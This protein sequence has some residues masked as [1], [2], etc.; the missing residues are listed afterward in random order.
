MAALW[1]SATSLDFAPHSILCRDRT[2]LTRSSEP[3][4]HGFAIGR[5]GEKL[6]SYPLDDPNAGKNPAGVGLGKLGGAKG[7]AARPAAI[8]TRRHQAI[9][10]KVARGHGGEATGL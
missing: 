9:A 1:C 5:F 8:S 6:A 3:E 4:D 2:M 10:K 7:G